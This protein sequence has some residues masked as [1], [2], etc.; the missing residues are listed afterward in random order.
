M[1]PI[2]ESDFLNPLIEIDTLIDLKFPFIC[3]PIKVLIDSVSLLTITYS[4]KP[5]FWTFPDP[6]LDE[7]HGVLPV[8]YFI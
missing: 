5:N 2:L 6:L 3:S 1:I 7:L 4:A 8:R